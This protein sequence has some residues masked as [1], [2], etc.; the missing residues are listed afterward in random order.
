MISLRAFL[1][2]EFESDFKSVRY[3]IGDDQKIDATNKLALYRSLA[4][5]RFPS[6][7]GVTNVW[8]DFAEGFVIYYHTKILKKPFSIELNSSRES[9]I[10]KSC[11]QTNKCKGK[12]AIFKKIFSN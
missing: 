11:L 1:R 12:E 7:Y 6:L 9:L 10:F 2:K 8:D 3:Y 4:K 5:S